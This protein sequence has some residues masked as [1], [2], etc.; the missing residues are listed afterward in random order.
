MLIYKLNQSE[1]DETKSVQSSH[2][3]HTA[4]VKPKLKLAEFTPSPKPIEV[5]VRLYIIR[6]SE[7]LCCWN[8]CCNTI[9]V[10]S[11]N[12]TIFLCA[13]Q[14]LDLHPEDLNGQAD[15]YLIVQLGRRV[16]NEK[17]RRQHNTL[18]PFF[19]R[20]AVPLVWC[21]LFLPVKHPKWQENEIQTRRPLWPL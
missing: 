16:R 2:R 10:L 19:G 9:K 14:A 17:D 20:C 6:V 5:N 12:T 15:P 11:Q 7:S 1:G 4:E 18:Q 13:F 21:H 8:H 3:G